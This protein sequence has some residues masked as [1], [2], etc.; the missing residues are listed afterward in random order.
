[1]EKPVFCLSP[2]TGG[3]STL[4]LLKA[5]QMGT[6]GAAPLPTLSRTGDTPSVLSRMVSP[7][8][9]VFTCTW[10]LWRKEQ[11]HIAVW[12]VLAVWRDSRHASATKQLHE[13]RAIW[14]QGI[15]IL[16]VSLE[17]AQDD[18]GVAFE[19]WSLFFKLTIEHKYLVKTELWLK[20]YV[21]FVS[22]WLNCCS[23]AH[24]RLQRRGYP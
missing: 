7:C 22:A 15:F 11:K 2:T 10:S 4:A 16:S 20:G 1:M 21:D 19:S 17:G 8:Q 3:L 18:T 23:I 9:R 24:I 14:S 12:T 5:A 6:S 13:W